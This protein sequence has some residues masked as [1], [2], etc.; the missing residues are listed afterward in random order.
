MLRKKLLTVIDLWLQDA[1]IRRYDNYAFKPHNNSVEDYEYNSWV[2]FKLK[3]M[4]L[5]ENE[6]VIYRW[7][8]YMKNL[9]N[10]DNVV[11]YIILIII[12]YFDNRLQ[13]PANRNIVCIVIYGEEGDGEN[14]LCDIFK[15]IFGENYYTELERAK[16]NVWFSFLY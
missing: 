16:T 1:T 5:E 7:L 3:Q 2:D 14:R 8:E 4:L 11:Q 9:F 13:N 10:D 12:A 6:E 15:N